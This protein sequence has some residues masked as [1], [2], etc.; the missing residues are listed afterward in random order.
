MNHFLVA[1]P[2]LDGTIFD[3]SVIYICEHDVHGAMGLIINNTVE[4]YDKKWHFLVR[5]SRN[6]LG[7]LRVS[8]VSLNIVAIF[9]EFEGLD[10][11]SYVFLS[12]VS[13]VLYSIICVVF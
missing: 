3:K 13:T 8:I 9:F 12:N 10:F 6:F 11:L 1:M 4:T 2:D 7:A 5:E